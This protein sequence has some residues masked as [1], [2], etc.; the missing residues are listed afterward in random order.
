MHKNLEYCCTS[1][2]TA[3]QT[4]LLYHCLEFPVC[5]FV[6]VCVRT[7]E[8][9]HLCVCVS[10]CM[11]VSPPACQTVSL[12]VWSVSLSGLTHSKGTALW[13]QFIPHKK[14][15]V[16]Q[17][18]VRKNESWCAKGVLLHSQELKKTNNILYNSL[19]A[20]WGLSLT[21]KGVSEQQMSSLAHRDDCG[22]QQV[23][24]AF[25]Q[26]FKQTL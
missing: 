7:T 19:G 17:I 18:M 11:C 13:M 2:L 22:L 8:C 26:K 10:M 24:D 6:C 16:K 14:R 4:P 20:S 1:N 3:R 5:M 23:W 12:P 25:L 9:V 15:Q 21:L